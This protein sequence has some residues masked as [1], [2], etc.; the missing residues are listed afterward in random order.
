MYMMGWGV[1]L[2]RCARAKQLENL[3]VLGELT[4]YVKVGRSHE[5]F[6]RNTVA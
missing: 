6:L 2:Q 4:F 3:I 1:S 5:M